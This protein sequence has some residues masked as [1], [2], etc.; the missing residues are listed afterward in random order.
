MSFKPGAIAE[1]ADEQPCCA[2]EADLTASNQM[3]VHGP[4]HQWPEHSARD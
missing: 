3:F 4:N 1:V 2:I